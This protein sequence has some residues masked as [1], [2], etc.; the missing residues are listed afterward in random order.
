MLRY[1]PNLKHPART[2]RCNMTDSEQLLWSRL[3]RK[4]ILG[5]QFYRPKPLGNFI[6]DFY[7]PRA[8]LVVEVDGSQHLD[9]SHIAHDQERT[10]YLNHQGLRVLRFDNLQVLQ[11][12][13]SV[14]EAIFAAVQAGAN[15][16]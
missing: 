1:N 15:P 16:P 12:L 8:R 2:L 6:V 10:V 5:V 11:Q 3:G 7:A 4:Q 13:E 14:V 9:P